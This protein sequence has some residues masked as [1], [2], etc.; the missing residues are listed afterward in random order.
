MKR[1]EFV[2]QGTAL[3]AGLT[4]GSA[5]LPGMLSATRP[6]EQWLDDPETRALA[7]RAVDAARSAGAT[8]ADVRISRSRQ[9]ALGTREHQITFFNDADTYGFGVRVLAGGA[10]GFA[11]SR[12]VNAD[13]VVRVA[14]QAVAQARAN[15]AAMKR[16]VQLAPAERYPDGKWQSPMEIDPFGIP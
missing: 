5:L 16:P 10:W 11:A 7:L 2:L 13:E 6:R 3:A 1:R 8:Y 4:A 14:R 15:S 9:Q 12:D